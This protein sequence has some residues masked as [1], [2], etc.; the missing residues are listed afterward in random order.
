MNAQDRDY[1]TVDNVTSAGF[2]SSN[3]THTPDITIDMLD[4]RPGVKAGP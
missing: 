1:E 2:D 4:K 3:H